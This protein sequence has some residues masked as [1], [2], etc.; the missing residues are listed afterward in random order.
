[1]TLLLISVTTTSDSL[2][3]VWLA[4]GQLR[5]S[6]HGSRRYEGRRSLSLRCLKYWSRVLFLDFVCHWADLVSR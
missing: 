3:W 2:D 1:M 4:E 5:S 6:W